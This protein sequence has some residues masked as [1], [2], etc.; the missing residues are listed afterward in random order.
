MEREIFSSKKDEY[1]DD[2]QEVLNSKDRGKF[3]E[4]LLKDI[5]AMKECQFFIGDF[6]SAISRIT[7]E[8]M[9]YQRQYYPPFHSMYQPWCDNAEQFL[10]NEKMYWC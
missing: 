7:Y 4:E 3:V 9:L 5:W 2:N 8:L 1:F 10:F 6:T